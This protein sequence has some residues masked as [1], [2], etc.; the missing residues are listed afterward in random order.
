MPKPKDKPLNLTAYFDHA[1][2]LDLELKMLGELMG[3]IRD[4]EF[5]SVDSVHEM[6]HAIEKYLNRRWAAECHFLNRSRPLGAT[7]GLFDGELARLK[8][9]LKS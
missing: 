3:S 8:A 1:F 2:G 5:V 6:G 4:L 7:H 9:I